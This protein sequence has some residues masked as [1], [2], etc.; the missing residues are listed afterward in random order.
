[1]GGVWVDV[2]REVKFKLKKKII[3]G[4]GSGFGGVRVWMC[5]KN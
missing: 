5:T 2:N 4:G 3:W 1:M